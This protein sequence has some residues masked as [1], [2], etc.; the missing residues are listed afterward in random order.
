VDPLSLDVVL[1]YA[2][3]GHGRRA[4]L[5]SDYTFAL[6]DGE[7]WVPVA[8]AYSG[9]T[10]A[11]IR[12]VDRW[13]RQNVKERFGPVRAVPPEHVF[14]LAFDGIQASTRHRSGVALRFPRMVRWRTDKQPD[15]AN[16]LEDALALL[17]SHGPN[18]GKGSGS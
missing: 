4:S 10:D 17:H 11:Q 16:T 15:E 8:K 13:V 7:D 14:E 1:L 18:A 5:Y 2:Q 3:R 9:L 12:E 6:R